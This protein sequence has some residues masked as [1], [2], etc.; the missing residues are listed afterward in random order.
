MFESDLSLAR[1]P[2]LGD[3]RLR[4][5][6]LLPAAAYVEMALA[7]AGLSGM[8]EGEV[9]LADLVLHGPLVVPDHGETR[10]Q[11]VLDPADTGEH[12]VEIWSRQEAAEPW[13]LT[14]RGRLAARPAPAGEP[15]SVLELLERCPREIAGEALYEAF[16]AE[17]YD[18]G[19]SFR[20]VERVWV[21][22][23]EALG[24]I[25]APAALLDGSYGIHPALLDACFHV[26]R[27]LVHRDGAEGALLPVGV[28][29]FRLLLRT[30]RHFWVHARLLP[31]SGPDAAQVALSVFGETGERLAEC[32][33]LLLRRTAADR[34]SQAEDVLH[35]L[36]WRPEPLPTPAPA[37]DV[38][39]LLLGDGGEVGAAM[40]DRLSRLGETTTLVC[41]DPSS[42]EDIELALRAADPRKRLRVLH[43][44]ALGDLEEPSLQ[45]RQRILLG[46]LPA[47]AQGV[48]AAER[49]GDCRI[50]IVTAG[51]QAAG[52][53]PASGV[54]VEQASLWGAGRVLAREH[55]ELWGGLVDLRESDPGK[56]A[57][58]LLDEIAGAGG[59]AGV[60]YVDGRR[61]VLR[62]RRCAPRTTP[63]AAF[64]AAGTWLISG[65]L[66][67]LGLRVAGWLIEKGVRHLVLVSRRAAPSGDVEVLRGSGAEVR[68]LRADISDSDQLAVILSEIAGSMPPLRGVIHA[69]GALDDALL[70]QQSPDRLERAWAPKI[71]GS[72]NLHEHTRHLDLGCF[73]LFSSA[74]AVLGT[75]GQAG[76]AAGNAFLDALAHERR[77]LGLPAVSIGW[78][79]WA[80]SGM[81]ASQDARSRERWAAQGFGELAPAAGLAAFA[82]ALA[83]NEPHVLALPLDA[84]RLAGSVLGRDPLFRDL[85]PAVAGPRDGRTVG[86]PGRLTR[87][88]LLAAARAERPAKLVAYLW[89]R[90]AAALHLSVETPDLDRRINQLG[91]DSLTVMELRNGLKA[92]L[93][94]DVSAVELF[95]YPTVRE[96]AD[97]IL[98]R[99]ESAPAAEPAAAPAPSPVQVDQLSD[100]EVEAMLRQL[101][102]EEGA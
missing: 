73:V 78:G 84:A 79:P 31:G 43:L 70:L 88:E 66:G 60:A 5:A 37:E 25:E 83:R 33:E 55:P 29:R 42:A 102:A 40:A 13:A 46:S 53:S 71:L 44:W 19:P 36:V 23:G 12:T 51:A 11:V 45:E 47:L 63:P 61:H 81:A 97:R 6:A 101:M 76:Y 28:E 59:E 30:G 35:E 82:R 92:D 21:G 52:A 41:C 8:A 64:D 4:E 85:A 86:R 93:R 24:W 74:A 26:A 48:F 89:D 67:A 91:M 39:W 27:P 99:L 58:L 69:A 22:E 87:A 17:S 15:V 34:L 98:P 95:E 16:A 2:F 100:D 1:L 68:V 80:G 10:V 62:L 14:A 94:V 49:D 77:R 32:G 50:W 96:L 38:H 65:G 3:H 90:V 75:P 54:A 57:A 20:G 72:W 9:E 56:A 7:A 18:Y